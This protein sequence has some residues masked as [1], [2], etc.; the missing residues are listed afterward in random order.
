MDLSPDKKTISFTVENILGY[1][2]ADYS[3][4]YTAYNTPRGIIG[5]GVDVA[6]QTQLSKTGLDL[7]SCSNNICTYDQ[8]ISDVKLS[9]SLVNTA[10][11]TVTIEK[12]L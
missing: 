10:G 1:S 4:T 11:T 5:S 7:A 3:L 12:A 8:N 9:V 2:T 6:G